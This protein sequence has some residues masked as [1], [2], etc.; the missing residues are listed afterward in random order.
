[1]L[2]NMFYTSFSSLTAQTKWN[3]SN[4]AHHSSEIKHTPNFL[5]YSHV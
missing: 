4:F 2:T 1:M 3:M 5:W